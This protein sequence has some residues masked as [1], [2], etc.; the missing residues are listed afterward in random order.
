MRNVATAASLALLTACSAP[1]LDATPRFG[2]FDIE[3][4]LGISENGVTGEADLESAGLDQD[5]SVFGA[6]V[7]LDWGPAH[8]M[9]S[10]QQSEH[11]GSGTLDAT[12]SSGGVTIPVGTD[13][14]SDLDLGLYSGAFT[15]DLIPTD[16]VELGIG[17]GVSYVDFSA[18]FQEQSTGE[19]VDVDEAVP[20]PLVAARLGTR[21]WRL[22]ASLQASGITWSDSGD[23]LTL[24]D[25]DLMAKLRLLG[26]DDRFAGHLT[27]GYR[28]LDLAFDYEGDDDEAEGDITF[29]GPYIGV[30][31]SI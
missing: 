18:S 3:G 8:L 15:F 22:D 7:D 14:D 28:W 20:V 24:I 13:V 25:L 29:D 19:T 23:E 30:T 1:R 27:A 17:L 12:I 6:R 31:L 21:I 11:G 16:L 9:L 4:S 5:D 10:G 2:T 26:D